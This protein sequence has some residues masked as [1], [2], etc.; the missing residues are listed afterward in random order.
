MEE[1]EEKGERLFE[2]G[3]KKR[4]GKSKRRKRESRTHG[5]EKMRMSAWSREEMEK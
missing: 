2:G 1:L 3:G 5:T 4:Q